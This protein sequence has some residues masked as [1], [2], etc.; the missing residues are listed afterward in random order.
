MNAQH[1]NATRPA[2]QDGQGPCAVAPRTH[3]CPSAPTPPPAD[4]P[5]R[6][7]SHKDN[8]RKANIIIAT[9]NVNGFSAPSSSLSGIEKWSTIVRM[10]NK[11]KITILAI[12]ET[13]L[14]D[15][16]LDEISTLFER[17]ITVIASHNPVT[18]RASAG[19]AFII[20]K[21][22]IKPKE[23]TYYELQEGRALALRVK[24]HENGEEDTTLLNIYAPNNKA[25]HR[26]FWENIETKRRLYRLRHPEFMLGDFNVTEDNIDRAP[27]HPDDINAITALRE[28]R[29]NWELQ[30][31]WRHSHPTERSF[32]FCTNANGQQIQSRLDRIYTARGT[33]RHTYGWHMG[34]TPTPTDHWIVM[35]KYSPRDAPLIGPGR[36]T[37][38]TPALRRNKLMMRV[39]A[40]GIQLQDEIDKI[41]RDMTPREISNPQRLWYAF[42]QDITTI[43]KALTKESSHKIN[44]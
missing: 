8:N 30:D 39:V 20:N 14:D 35:T 25:E 4:A 13:H 34:P 7:H 18:P 22:L 12:Q 31:A 42:K 32:T 37:W 40:R 26:H 44:S 5:T 11:L 1:H 33:S 16:R 27:A 23:I 36:W 43:A 2:G 24:W 38:P 29:H 6:A 17:K 3:P 15:T 9:L 19:V 21:K 10:M 41:K 28:I